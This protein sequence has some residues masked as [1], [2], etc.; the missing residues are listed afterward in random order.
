MEKFLVPRLGHLAFTASFE[1][2]LCNLALCQDHCPKENLLGTTKFASF[3]PP[4]I[5]QSITS[6]NLIN[7]VRR[8]LDYHLEGLMSDQTK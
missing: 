4:E 8:R 7:F 2:I 1:D 6:E 5:R 3:L